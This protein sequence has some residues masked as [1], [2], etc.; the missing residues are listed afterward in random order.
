MQIGGVGVRGKTLGSKRDSSQKAR[1]KTSPFCA[2]NDGLFFCGEPRVMTGKTPPARR[3][4]RRG[5]HRGR[6]D[7]KLYLTPQT[8]FGMAGFFVVPLELEAQAE[9]HYAG[10]AA[11]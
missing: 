10:A 4:D 5:I 1:W 3:G 9:L 7:G 11:T 2:R 6:R 8:P